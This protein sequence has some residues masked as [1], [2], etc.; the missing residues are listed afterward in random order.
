MALMLFHYNDFTNTIIQHTKANY[1][2]VSVSLGRS[3]IALGTFLNLSFNSPSKILLVKEGVQNANYFYNKYSIF[4]LLQDMPQLGHFISLT[5]LGIVI[6]GWRPRFTCIPHAYIS[7]SYSTSSMVVEGGD[8]I[9]TII[10]IFL[11]PLLIFD[12]R[13]NHWRSIIEPNGE[14]SQITGYF[15]RGLIRL[16]IAVIYLH[17]AVGKF[18]SQSWKDGSS[19]YYLLNDPK[20][21]SP[22]ANAGLFSVLL[23]NSFIISLLSWGAIALELIIACSLFIHRNSFQQ[24]F[25]IFSVAIIFHACIAVFLGL[26]SFSLIMTGVLILYYLWGA[27]QPKLLINRDN[28]AKITKRFN[29]SWI[30]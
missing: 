16:Q 12:S 21:G 2:T 26:I 27:E 23:R 24:R 4:G 29:Q 10:T 28:V 14:I 8:Q 30:N 13:R 3:F 17:A 15:V 1:W 7:Y 19:I 9:A 5:I 25:I 6:L 18:A 11:I 20:F 22:M